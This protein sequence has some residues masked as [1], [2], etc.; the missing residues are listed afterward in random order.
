ME[1]SQKEFI[2]EELRSMQ[3]T[4]GPPKGDRLG[5][6]TKGISHFD[7]ETTKAILDEELVNPR[8]VREELLAKGYGPS[9][10]HQAL[11]EY[12]IGLRVLNPLRRTTPCFA[13]TLGAFSWK[14]EDISCDM[15]ILY[16]KVQG[17]TLS[18]M[19]QE[20]MSFTTWLRL[21]F[22]VL[23]SLEVAQRRTGFTHY[24]LHASNVVVTNGTGL[25]YNIL[26]D[27]LSYQ[28]SKPKLV[29]V[30]IDFGT[31]STSLEG[32]S[33]G[34]YD[35]ANSGIFHFMVSGHDMYRLMVSSYHHAK[36]SDTRRLILQ[37]F[38][39]FGE[40]DPY[41]IS[42]GQ[43]ST[44]V[45]RAREEFCRAVALS[46][47][48]NYTPMMMI[49]YTYS[50]F[51]RRLAPTIALVPRKVHSSLSSLGG[52]ESC[53]MALKSVY[54]LITMKS[55]YIVPSYCLS[56]ASRVADPEVKDRINALSTRLA[57]SKERCIEED[58]AILGDVFNIELPQQEELSEAREQLLKLPIRHRNASVKEQRFDNLEAMLKYQD[59]TQPFLDSYFTLMEL[60]F[61]EE[62]T[63]WVEAFCRSRVYKFYI[64]NKIENDRSWRWGE[65]LLASIFSNC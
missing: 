31:C 20:G 62:Y 33:I 63:V 41:S 56:V 38:S 46:K 25:G 44:G 21:F 26:I 51:Y 57:E 3:R 4:V 36:N 23:L 50:K 14:S 13:Y 34:S 58:L 8:G 7:V 2:I 6:L 37:L 48:A 52:G 49:K 10:H 5:N 28:I 15:A 55:G 16:E 18:I 22:Q 47:I 59:E 64:A 29:P 19:L 17:P 35:Y 30:I 42:Q 27:Y 11:R 40:D 32:R 9:A 61:D 1:H 54:T 60:G 53:D 39:F 65:T 43:G 12:L 24:D 45:A